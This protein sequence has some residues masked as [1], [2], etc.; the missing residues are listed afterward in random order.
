MNVK[1]EVDTSSPEPSYLFRA[2]DDYKMGT[3][4]GFELD[5]HDAEVA[6]IQNPKEHVLRNLDKQ[7]DI[8]LFLTLW[9]NY[10]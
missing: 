7:V 3:P 10:K 2:D 8:C 9:M 4:V 5:S 6:D 1:E